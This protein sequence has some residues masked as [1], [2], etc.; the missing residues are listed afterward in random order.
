MHKIVLNIGLLFFFI[1]IIIFSQLKK[2]PLE[3][4]WKSFIVF[5]IVTIMLN[6]FFILL[7]KFINKISFEKQY[8]NEKEKLIDDLISSDKPNDLQ[9]AQIKGLF[10]SVTAEDNEKSG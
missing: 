4:L 1:F 2:E 8:A 3:I 5:A 9:D 7:T 10:D 6:L